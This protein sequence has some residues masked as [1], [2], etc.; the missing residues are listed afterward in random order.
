MKKQRT[1]AQKMKRRTSHRV[2]K[3]I[4]FSKDTRRKKNL[5][6]PIDPFELPL[7]SEKKEEAPKA[8]KEY[9]RWRKQVVIGNI[10]TFVSTIYILGCM[11][12]LVFGTL[13]FDYKALLVEF[14]KAM[15]SGTIFSTYRPNTSIPTFW[16]MI[17]SYTWGQPVIIMF[18]AM[19][20]MV[21]DLIK[22]DATKEIEKLKSTSKC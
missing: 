19:A 22:T 7:I 10:M 5:F 3:R 4:D 15:A 20:L 16:D 12:F 21:G 11:V 14:A 8:K 17:V 18:A 6:P 2:G 13:F 1:L 9:K